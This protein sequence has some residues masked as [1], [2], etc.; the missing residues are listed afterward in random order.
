MRL[1]TMLILAASML[2]GNAAYLL[3]HGNSFSYEEIK[4]GYLIDIGYD[5]FIAAEESVRFDF[6]VYP[7]DIESVEGEVFTDVWVTITQ[8]KQLF[9]AGGVHKPV[10]GATG[11]TY[12]FPQEG[13]YVL[14]ARFQ[15]GGET[16]VNTEFPITV[17]PPLDQGSQMPPT[18]VYVL[19]TLAGLFIGFA[20]GILIPRKN[21]I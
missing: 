5:E 6:I 20:A 19:C 18:V 13:E 3:A 12:A 21:K 2:F 4:D 8:D 1:L 17:I 9:F 16:V 11:F 10:Y 14:S 15:N 7:E